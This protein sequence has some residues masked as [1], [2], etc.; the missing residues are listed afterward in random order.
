[1]SSPI[2]IVRSSQHEKGIPEQSRGQKQA[3]SVSILKGVCDSQEED[4]GYILKD[5]SQVGHYG[6]ISG[7]THSLVQGQVELMLLP[8]KS[9]YSVLL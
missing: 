9:L 3:N 6:F 8:S 5:T 4:L 7:W 1:M 2:F